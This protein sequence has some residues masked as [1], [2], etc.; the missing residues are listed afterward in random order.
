MSE[1]HAFCS[2]A[3]ADAS[4]TDPE[5]A[6]AFG[7][8]QLVKAK[9]ATP[10][11]KGAI[12]ASLREHGPYFVLAPGLAL[13]H[14]APGE[15]CLE[16]ALALAVFPA[17]VRFSDQERHAVRVLVTLSAPDAKSHMGLIAWFARRFGDGK[18]TQ[19]LCAAKSLAEAE[20]AIA[21]PE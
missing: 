16:P 20:A 7:V 3:Y 12:M 21:R 4:I 19:R 8:D 13:A 5:A 9:K 1:E 15:Y 2:V 11:L 6:I 17:P 18:L 10:A 14:A